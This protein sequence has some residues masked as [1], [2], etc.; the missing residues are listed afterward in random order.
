[1][2]LTAY[3]ARDWRE[4]LPGRYRGTPSSAGRRRN[5]RRGGRCS[6][7]RRR[8]YDKRARMIERRVLL[9]GGDAGVVGVLREY[10]HLRAPWRTWPRLS[11][12]ARH[13]GNKSAIQFLKQKR[14]IH[15]PVPVVVVS[16]SGRADVEAE[17]PSPVAH[18]PSSV[19][20][21]IYTRPDPGTDQAG[22]HGNRR[23]DVTRRLWLVA[24]PGQGGRRRGRNQP[25]SL[26]V[27]I[28]GARHFIAMMVPDR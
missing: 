13:T 24:S 6:G 8:C 28:P 1:M 23:Q 21:S 4:L 11:S 26:D 20:R 19:S 16:G 12:P 22:G 15:N 25:F 27:S 5:R 14:A 3:A 10:F 18:W 9:V 7:R 2:Q 17:A